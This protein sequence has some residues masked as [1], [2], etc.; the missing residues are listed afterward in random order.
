MVSA[1]RELLYVNMTTGFLGGPPP[2]RLLRVFAF[3][4]PHHL[5]RRLIHAQDFSRFHRLFEQYL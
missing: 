5:Y 3:F 2:R 4:F 1:F